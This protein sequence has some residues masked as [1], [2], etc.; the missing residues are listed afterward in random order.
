MKV[1]IITINYNNAVGLRRTIESIVSKNLTDIEYIVI[2]GNSTDE[3]VGVI[4]EYSDKISYWV[5]E[6]D[7]GIYNAMNKGIRQATGEYVIFIN[8]GD[9]ICKHSDM[10]QIISQISGEDIIYFNLEINDL[11]TNIG[12]TKEYP[13]FPDFKYF[14]E[15]TLPHPGSFIKKKSLVDYGYYNEDLKITSDWAFFMD[16]ICINKC[17]YKHINACFSIFYLDGISSNTDSY[18]LI[19]LE[20]KNHIASAYP[21]YTSIYE[22]WKN[23]K[24]ELYKLKTSISVRYLK[25]FGFLKWLKL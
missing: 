5:S 1:S 13:D 6:P 22:D 12:Y 3:S 8:S 10:Q 20:R 15:D 11:N 7:A 24:Q 17:T 25:K 14:I 4:K 21:L 19:F 23:V 18:E 2:D 9:T 16:S